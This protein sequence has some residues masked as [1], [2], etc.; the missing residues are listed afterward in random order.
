MATAWSGGAPTEVGDSTDYELGTRWRA[1]ETITIT[2][3]RITT[4]AGE[5]GQAGRRA[6]LWDDAGVELA[7]TAAFDDLPTGT[8]E[9]ALTSPVTRTAGQ[10]FRTSYSTYGNYSALA[11]AISAD[12]PSADGAVTALATGTGGVG[13]GLFNAGNPGSFPTTSGGGTYYGVDFTYSLG[14]GG[15][16]APRITGVTAIAAAAVVTA[17]MVVEDDETLV[18]ASYRFEWGDG[19]ATTGVTSAQHTY[20]ASGT[21]AVL[22]QVTDAGGL[23][24]A[25]ATPVEVHVP[26]EEL[27]RIDAEALLDRAR[28]HAAASGL[29]ET[30][31]GHEPLHPPGSGV[32]AAVWLGPI[33][34][35]QGRSG[36]GLTSA[37]LVLFLR[38]FI[39]PDV[40]DLG[41]VERRLARAM[42]GLIYLYNGDFTVGGAAACIDL[43]GA[44]GDALGA[45]P[46][47]VTVGDVEFRT[48]T[49]T[50]PLI[51]DN[52]WEQVA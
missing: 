41:D 37:R 18:G 42:D 3:V 46:G 40:T 15:N 22:A 45:V 52:A 16:T 51:I 33:T 35:V 2:H 21:Y 39:R 12:V 10:I 27:Q 4:G 25:A 49:F 38:V 29:F 47:Y 5:T 6:R 44:F 14:A 30:V 19:S 1:E 23:V 28:S 13:N 8:Y 32:H 26:S 11:G 48:A 24:D 34:P 20:A 9:A 31:D 36:L 17:T 43:L 7:Q 50:I